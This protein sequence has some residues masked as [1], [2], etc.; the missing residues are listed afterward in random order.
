MDVDLVNLDWTRLVG[1]YTQ[2]ELGLKQIET[3]LELH[4]NGAYVYIKL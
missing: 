3:E 2:G 1:V 4:G